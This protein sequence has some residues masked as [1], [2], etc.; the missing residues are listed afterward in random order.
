MNYNTIKRIVLSKQKGTFSSMVWEKPLPIRKA[1]NGITIVKRTYG[2]IRL[3][4]TYDN[5]GAVK[6]KREN[7]QLPSEN[8]G[9]TWGAWSLFPYFI[10]HK[11]NK[12]LRVS[13]DKNNKLRSEYFLNGL[14][15]TKEQA[16]IYCT[17]AA[18]SN[19]NIPDVLSVNIDNIIALK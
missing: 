9:L 16:Q 1:Y 18:F 3:G 2:T 13:L 10:E 12:Y 11:G 7:G 19:G 6:E 8:M 14:P 5:M 4:V 17:K 15:C